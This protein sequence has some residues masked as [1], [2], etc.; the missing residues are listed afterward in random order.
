MCSPDLATRRLPWRSGLRPYLP[1]LGALAVVGLVGLW[2]LDL[3]YTAF[4]SPIDHIRHM[5]T[6]GFNL[7]DRYTPNSITSDPWQWLVNDVQFDYLKVAVNTSVNGETVG[8]RPSIEFRA[9]INP[10]LLAGMAIVI[11]WSI[12]QAWRRRDRLA[13]WALVWMGAN[14][15]PYVALALL[16]NRVMY[17][18][19]VLPVIPG[20]AALSAL[21]LVR[22]KLPRIVLVAYLLLAAGAFLAWFPFRQLPS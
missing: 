16:T 6:Y 22:A 4:T 11:P 8:S 7:A 9:L 12:H 1:M 5:L 3:R 18:Y 10:V 13:G 17:F 15:L 14:W 2:L 20:L 19:Y 21:F